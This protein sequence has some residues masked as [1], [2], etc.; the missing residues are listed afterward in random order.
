MKIGFYPKLALTGIKKNKR[1]YIPYIITCI[2]MIMMYYIIYFLST[3]P[4]V[5]HMR[6]GDTMQMILNL[7]KW[8]IAIFSVEFLFYTNS[9]LVRRRKKEFG[10]YNI[11]G[12]NKKNIGHIL[13]WETLIIAATSLFCGLFA[14][15]ALSKFAELGLVNILKGKISFT[16]SVSIKAII[17]SAFLYLGIFVLIFLNTLRQ[18]H[19][20]NPI[21]LFRSENTGEKPP[22]ANWFFGLFGIVL[23]AVAYY[24]AVTIESPLTALIW[25]FIAVI[26][27]IIGT[28]LLFISSSVLFCR[29]LQKKKDYYYK[30]NHFVSVSSMVYRMKR[31]GA[32]LASICILATMVLVMLTGSACLY[33]GVEDSLHTRYP[34][35]IN[36]TVSLNSI[37][38]MEN[39]TINELREKVNEVV[40][41]NTTTTNTVV[42][43][44]TTNIAGALEGNELEV[45]PTT[46]NTFSTEAFNN[47]RQVYFISVSDYNQLMGTEEEINTGEAMIYTVRCNYDYD[48]FTIKNGVTFKITKTL[49]KFYN[50][51]NMEMDIAPSIVLVVPDYKESLK[52][53]INQKASNGNPLLYQYWNY[54]FNISGNEDK[55]LEIAKDIR[56]IITTF[57]DNSTSIKYFY[58]DSLEENRGDFYGTYG[59]IF[60]LGIMLSIVFIFATV[61][62]IY[63]KQISEGYEDQSRF[64]IMQK[65]GMTKKDIRKS[66]NSQMLTVFSLPLV[67]AII[68]LS[69]AFPMIRRLLMIFNLR[70]LPLLLTTASISVFVFALFYTIVYRITSNAYYTIVSGV[71]EN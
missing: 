68:H 46:V 51:T 65:V 15:I 49:D 70:N 14:G 39:G 30:S 23:L 6:G 43:Y 47:L 19:T 26:M 25:F 13:L 29:L 32:G 16:L 27:V 63:Y 36:I 20:A 69:F 7:G 9:F 40:K 58:C 11:L 50:N 8:V 37:E 18:I 24:L 5:K 64:E 48:T 71:K 1:L 31:N 55:Q 41:D 56:E 2:G 12:M 3:T 59:G 4:V 34:N 57:S 33:F 44:R 17:Q 38:D 60:F 28:Y 22:K 42:D 45:D 54:G 67:T 61:L 35:D 10:L 21:A 52:P 53:L 62:I 66:I